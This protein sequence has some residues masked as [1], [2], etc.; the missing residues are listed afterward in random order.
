[1]QNDDPQ[2]GG[3][4]T[5]GFEAGQFEQSLARINR[6]TLSGLALMTSGALPA[7]RRRCTE[8]Q[9]LTVTRPQ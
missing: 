7:F 1:M 2:M 8:D 9:N 3:F 6:A 5:R 4:V